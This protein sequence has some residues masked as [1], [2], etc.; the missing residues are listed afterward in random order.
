VGGREEAGLSRRGLAS[1]PLLSTPENHLGRRP[2]AVRAIVVSQQGLGAL[3][4]RGR[5]APRCLGSSRGR[6][7]GAAAGA[8]RVPG[9]LRRERRGVKLHVSRS[10]CPCAGLCP[11]SSGGCAPARVLGRVCAAPRGC[12]AAALTPPPLFLTLS[13]QSS[14]AFDADSPRLNSLRGYFLY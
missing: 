4:P 13:A 1:A 9:S 10:L 12:A 3:L 5:L 14:N 7:G 2:V 8:G 6:A 11:G